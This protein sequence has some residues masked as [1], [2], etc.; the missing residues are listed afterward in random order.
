MQG[1]R[2]ALG[3]PA[4]AVLLVLIAMAVVQRP[5]VMYRVGSSGVRPPDGRNVGRDMRG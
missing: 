4:V 1:R 2:A 5:V 3:R